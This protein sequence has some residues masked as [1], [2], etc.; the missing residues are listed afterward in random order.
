VML[1]LTWSGQRMSAWLQR[2]PLRHVAA[3][4]VLLMGLLTLAAPWLMQLPAL[5]GALA[6]LGCVPLS[7]PVPY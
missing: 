2:P 7:H 4:L 1:P 6:A 5:H 3:G